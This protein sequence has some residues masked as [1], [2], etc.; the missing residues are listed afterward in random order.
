LFLDQLLGDWILVLIFRDNATGC[1]DLIDDLLIYFIS[2]F[3]NELRFDVHVLELFTT[4]KG[5]EVFLADVEEGLKT[6]YWLVF[7]LLLN[8]LR[9]SADTSMFGTQSNVMMLVALKSVMEGIENMLLNDL[10]RHSD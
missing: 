10:R 3:L 6:I 8:H 4:L 5:H 1:L 7:K 9:D 2:H